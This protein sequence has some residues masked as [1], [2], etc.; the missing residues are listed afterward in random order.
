MPTESNFAPV[1]E[2]G[3][4]TLPPWRIGS[5][6]LACW[7]TS[8]GS[9][10]APGA[11]VIGAVA[12]ASQTA[13]EGA[14][15][16]QQ[17]EG[18]AARG[19]KG[20]ERWRTAVIV[21]SGEEREKIARIDADLDIVERQAQGGEEDLVV[22]EARLAPG[23][24]QRAGVQLHIEVVAVAAQHLRREE[25]RS[26]GHALEEAL[27]QPFEIV[28]R[29]LGRLQHARERARPRRAPAQSGR[30]SPTAPSCA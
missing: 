25:I 9:S 19:G 5:P 13:T 4:S 18:Q 8:Y 27:L 15:R 21:G 3:A 6:S 17:A 22:G 24:L 12:G 23:V 10:L 30:R 20:D 11:F 7:N 2:I 29:I 26:P 14:Q 16:R 1:H 28:R